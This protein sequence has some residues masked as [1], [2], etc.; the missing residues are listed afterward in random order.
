MNPHGP[1]LIQKFPD[2]EFKAIVQL[3]LEYARK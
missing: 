3:N 1:T 2:E